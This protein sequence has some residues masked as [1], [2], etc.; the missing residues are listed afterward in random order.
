[1]MDL[2]LQRTVAQLHNENEALAMSVEVLATENARLREML[3]M[4]LD[5]AEVKLDNE[6]MICL[7]FGYNMRGYPKALVKSRDV[8]DILADI[9]VTLRGV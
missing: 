1:M 5:E 2:E 4:L 7:D 3:D 8:L 9:Y 6:D